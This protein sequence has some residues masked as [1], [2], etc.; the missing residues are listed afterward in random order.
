MAGEY[1]LAVLTVDV[2]QSR[3]RRDDI[4]EPARFDPSRHDVRL[5]SRLINLISPIYLIES[6]DLINL[7]NVD[8]CGQR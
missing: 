5:R 7:I 8:Q 4:F 6:I 1:E 2:A 3:R